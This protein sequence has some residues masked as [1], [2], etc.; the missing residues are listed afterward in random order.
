MKTSLKLRNILMALTAIGLLAV[1]GCNQI[2]YTMERASQNDVYLAGEMAND[3]DT[4]FRATYWKNGEPI[5]LT[6]GVDNSGLIDIAVSGNTVYTLGY[7]NAVSKYWKN[8]QATDLGSTFY[9]RKI[10]V[11]N[12]DVYVLSF[13]PTTQSAV[14]TKN[15]TPSVIDFHNK[16]ANTQL[17][18]SGLLVSGNDV[19]IIGAV[20]GDAITPM[21][22]KNGNAMPMTSVDGLLTDITISGNDIYAAGTQ[23]RHG[24]E[25]PATATYWKNGTPVYLTDGTSPASANS[26][27]ISGGDVYVAGSERG[28]NGVVVAK[29]WKNGVAI[30]LSDGTVGQQALQIKVSG[31]DVYVVGEATDSDAT[32]LWKNGHPVPPFDGTNPRMIFTR[33]WVD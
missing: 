4:T 1:H 19:Y 27:T 8:D 20:I 13:D 10:C 2:D 18:P 14:L 11:S 23:Y 12:N 5:T 3:H 24:H 22:W 16:P 31:N 28:S 6:N 29:Y 32:V 7:V 15:G 21:V 26:I 17:Y 30:N 25:Q 33:L 9:A